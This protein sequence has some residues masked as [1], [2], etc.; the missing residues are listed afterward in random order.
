MIVIRTVDRLCAGGLLALGVYIVRTALAY[1]YMRDAVPGPGFFPFWIGLGLVTLS[2]V[3]LLRSLRGHERLESRFDAVN[4]Y[5]TLAL[6]GIVLAFILIA[7]WIG[8]LAASGLLVPATACAI[9]PRWTRRFAAVILTT[10]VAFP[11]GAY[12]LFAVY[13]LVYFV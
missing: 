7:P 4:L 9:R 2:A 11:V 6:T 5:K 1:G 3:N 12:F 13:L 10:A 8:M